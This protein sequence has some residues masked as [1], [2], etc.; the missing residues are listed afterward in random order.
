MYNTLPT[1]LTIWNKIFGI[2]FDF[3]VFINDYS[4]NKDKDRTIKQKIICIFKLE[5]WHLQNLVRN[6]KNGILYTD[7]FLLILYK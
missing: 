7:F 4:K 6:V 2:C 1:F 3:S 5:Q